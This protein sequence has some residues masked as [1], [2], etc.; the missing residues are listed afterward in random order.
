MTITGVNSNVLKKGDPEPSAPAA[1][2][3]RLYNMRFCP[4][5]ERALIYLSAKGVPTEVVNIHLMEKP[6]WYFKKHYQGKVPALEHDGRIVI[7]SGVIPEYLDDLLPENRFLLSDPYE[8]AQQKLLLE[9]LSVVVPAFYGLF[10]LIKD[11]SAKEEKLGNLKKA[12]DEAEQLLQHEFFS[13]SKAGYVDFLI[14][15][16]FERIWWV[17]DIAGFAFP[18]PD[19]P[20]VAKWFKA[21]SELPEIARVIQPLEKGHLF[22]KSYADG[23]PD[24]DV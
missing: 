21:T 24:Y 20:K 19:H 23:K 14:F 8:K 9:R 1:G 10:S 16:F 5:A 6:E 4:W 17:S 2:T 15:P 3:Y 13:G 22:I 11:A 12:L 7:E 18:S